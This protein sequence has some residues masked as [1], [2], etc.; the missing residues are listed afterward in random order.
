[1]EKSFQNQIAIVTG[2]GTGI[3]QG[4]C[5]D[6]ANKGAKVI[7]T[8]RRKSMLEETKSIIEN[9]G[10]YAE[11]IELDVTN[12]ENINEVVEQVYTKYGKIDI[13]VNN[14]GNLS[15]PSF[16][17]NMKD[18][19]W[20]TVLKTH[21]YG[22]FYCVKAVSKK[23][24][25][26]KYG[27]IIMVSSVAAI[28]GFNGAINYASAKGGMEAM[29]LSLAKELGVDGITVNGIQPGIIRTP[30]AD[31]FLSAMEEIFTKDTPVKRIGEP[32]DVACAVSFYCLP[33][34]GFITGTI[35]KV[36]GGYML[37]SSMDQFV[38]SACNSNIE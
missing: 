22:A 31:G 34:A 30:M 21:L 23:M 37:Q 5:I 18:E 9:S 1:M 15:E 36:D 11:C 7:I 14:A 32:K 17:Y 8:G 12:T 38:N 16:V 33:E 35:I 10:G 26:K 4:I 24:K 28:N 29:T 13:F 3:G 20:D 6:L 2:G 27:R 19:A 25:E